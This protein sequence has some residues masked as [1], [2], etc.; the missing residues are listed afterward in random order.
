MALR[1]SIRCTAGALLLL[2]SAFVSAMPALACSLINVEV[3]VATSI[4]TSATYLIASVLVGALL[5]A[6]ELYRRR[7]SIVLVLA[8]A[9][10]VFH[11][12]WTVAPSYMP[13]CTFLNVE[14]S[15]AVLAALVVMLCYRLAESLVAYFRT[16]T[17]H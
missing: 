2:Q 16:S 12:Y 3:S 1:S 9:M 7:S 10:L 14:A 13:D 15:Q 4:K 11:P 6:L 17:N 8:T 5:I